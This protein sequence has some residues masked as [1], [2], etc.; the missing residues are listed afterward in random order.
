LAL[1]VLLALLRKHHVA[2]IEASADVEPVPV[3]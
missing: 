1:V 2:A 3:A